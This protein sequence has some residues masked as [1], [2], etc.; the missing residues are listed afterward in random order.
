MNECEEIFSK[1]YEA[2]GTNLG[3]DQ[4]RKV[5]N[6]LGRPST[7]FRAIHVA[8]TNGKGTVSTKIACT[9]QA[10][11][12]KVGLFTSPHIDTFR[13]RIKINGELISEK[14]ALSGLREIFNLGAQITFFEIMTLLAFCHFDRHGVDYAVIETGLGGRLDATNILKPVVSV[15]TNIS[16]DH[17]H[18]LGDTLDKIGAE[19]AGIIKPGVPVVLGSRAVRKTVLQKTFEA[20]APAY[21]VKHCD[22]A[23]DENEQI[24][25]ATLKVVLASNDIDVSED[26]PP[27]RFEEHGDIIFDGAHNEDGVV[28]LF[29]AVKRKYPGKK[30]FT[31]F[32]LSSSKEI[33]EIITLFKANSDYLYYHEGS[34]PRLASYEEVKAYLPHTNH[35]D[36]NKFIAKART[37]AGIIVVS[38]SFFI[39]TEIK[40]R[41]GIPTL[42]DPVLLQD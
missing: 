12:Y 33:P 24:A 14:E 25:K 23:Y 39:M 18:I 2:S 13:E 31:I 10:M 15:I 4:V 8:G 17:A 29:S 3:L 6:M 21:F 42:K 16:Y 27:C 37:E 9:L 26:R 38:G 41:F 19:K 20:K 7:R 28:Q 22:S 5:D 1:L 35:T 40:E 36:M 30:I 32:S 34:H 11:G